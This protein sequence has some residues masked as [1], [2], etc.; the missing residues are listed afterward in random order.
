MPESLSLSLKHVS[1]APFVTSFQIAAV[2][3]SHQVTCL[4]PDRYE[5]QVSSPGPR[6]LREGTGNQTQDCGG[7]GPDLGQLFIDVHEEK[8]FRTQLGCKAQIFSFGQPD[9][10]PRVSA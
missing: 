5:A 3:R 6:Y 2:G 8:R 9:R 10:F 1:S 7:K 4:L